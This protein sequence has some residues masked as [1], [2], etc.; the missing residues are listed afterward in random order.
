MCLQDEAVARE[1]L[2][3][4][5]DSY[6]VPAKTQ[7]LGLVRTGGLPSYVELLSC[8][9]LMRDARKIEGQELGARAKRQNKQT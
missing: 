2:V 9:E 8:I 7:C 6:P 1:T 3:K 5:W 4:A